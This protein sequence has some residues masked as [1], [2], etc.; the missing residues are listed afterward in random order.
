MAMLTLMF[1]LGL[2]KL[3]SVHAK[4]PARPRPLI[5]S[6]DP[7]VDDSIALLLA[8]ASPELDLRAVCI[9]FGS[10]HN[11]T[12]LAQNALD[13]LALA[14][15][16]DIPVY[17]GASDPLSSGFHDLG[18]MRFHGKDGLGGAERTAAPFHVEKKQSAPEFIA[19]A[20]R[21]WDEKPLLVS[22]AP[23]TNIALAL[24]LEPR[25]A[26]L[27]PD[28]FLMG[29][30]VAAPGNVGPMSEANIANDPDAAQRVIAAGFNAFFAGLDVTMSTWLDDAYLGSLRALPSFAGQFI[31]N[32]TRFYE[33]AYEQIAGF[34]GGMPLHDPSAIFMH[35][36]PALYV[37]QRWGAV[38]DVSPYPSVTRGLVL[39]D[40]RA[41]PLSPQP[42]RNVTT[43]FAMQVDAPRLLEVLR[44]RLASLPGQVHAV[45]DI[46]S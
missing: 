10:L 21:D 28:L 33:H 35:V 30:T 6:T 9:N 44:S 15:R 36:Q 25:L 3:H 29:G 23:L 32:I 46:L 27:C 4:L 13:V 38:V 12:Q 19:S 43:H 26:T 8:I 16:S 11:V 34:A 39:A 37:T 41:G 24:E 20:C 2:S 7:G 14:G 42:P 31:W 45:E 5:I 40:R 18:G 17:L 1:F 22:L